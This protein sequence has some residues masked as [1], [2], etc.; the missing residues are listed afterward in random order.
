M[1]EFED[2]IKKAVE[3]GYIKEDGFPLKCWKCNSKDLKFTC[4][5][6]DHIMVEQSVKCNNCGADVGLWSY[7]H[8]TV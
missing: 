4:H 2:E 5:Y 8:W 7:G 6:D 1:G 3:E